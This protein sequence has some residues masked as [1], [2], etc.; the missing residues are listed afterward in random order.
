MKVDFDEILDFFFWGLEVFTRRDC[1]LILVGLRQCQSQQQAE[2]MLARLRQRRLIRSEGRGRSARI[3]LTAEGATKVQ[4]FDPVSQWNK[5]W[6]GKWRLLAYDLPEQRRA[7]RSA[8]SHALRQRKIGL[9]QWSL[10]VWPHDLEPILSE[11]LPREVGPRSLCGFVCDRLY[12]CEKEAV[13]AA[14]WD[15]HGVDQAHQRHLDA[16]PRL[17]VS[18]KSAKDL[19]QVSALARLEREAYSKAFADDPL[20]PRALWPAGYRGTAVFDT[21]VRF[22]S[23][24]QARARELAAAPMSR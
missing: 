15:F 20:L 6:D 5:P 9:L 4:H 10:W 3:L 13:V 12:L 8:L 1:G 7:E 19:R 21:H 16:A 24:L 17:I 14:A 2:W 18:L 11:L 23:L 22:R